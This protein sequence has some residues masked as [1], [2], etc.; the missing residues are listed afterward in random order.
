MD[1]SPYSVSPVVRENP[2][3]DWSFLRAAIASFI[4]GVLSFLLVL[5]VVHFRDSLQESWAVLVRAAAFVSA[6]VMSLLTRRPTACAFA[7]FI[8][9]LSCLLVTQTLEYPV[10]AVIAFVVNGLIPALVGGWTAF[11]VQRFRRIDNVSG[12][13]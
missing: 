8:G 9:F 3:S 13:Q 6:F 4:C 10:S 2:A 11:V 12:P 1:E 7:V 5:A